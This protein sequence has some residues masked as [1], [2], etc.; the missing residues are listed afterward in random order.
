MEFKLY[1]KCRDCEKY[2]RK[3]CKGYQFSIEIVSI[4]CKEYE[5]HK[6]K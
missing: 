5:K 2:K 3:E 1:D 6:G 4:H